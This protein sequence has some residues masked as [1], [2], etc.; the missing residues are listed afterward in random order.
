M[1]K[2]RLGMNT[3]SQDIGFLCG[4]SN[5]STFRDTGVGT[6]D[7]PRQGDKTLIPKMFKSDQAG[8]T[9]IA[10]QNN[11][12]TENEWV[13]V[14]KLKKPKKKTEPHPM[15]TRS[16][17]RAE[18]NDGVN[19]NQEA[20]NQDPSVLGTSLAK[21]VTIGSHES[22]KTHPMVTRSRQTKV[23][24][25]NNIHESTV[26][27]DSM[28]GRSKGGEQLGKVSVIGSKGGR[29]CVKRGDSRNILASSHHKQFMNLGMGSEADKVTKRISC[30]AVKE[31]ETYTSHSH[32]KQLKNWE[33][34]SL[35]DK[36]AQGAR[37]WI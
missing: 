13:E 15:V 35:V 25:V 2:P 1:A 17:A 26:N 36:A 28:N 8:K 21:M 9:A 12:R 23:R 19:V 37:G 34:E 24:K 4:E 32:Y 18:R 22:N 30:V 5:R 29:V 16:K 14:V 10:V 3:H 33:V 27:K 6:D 11:T 31:T 20:K 7:Q